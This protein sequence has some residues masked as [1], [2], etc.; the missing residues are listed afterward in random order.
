M[1]FMQYYMVVFWGCSLFDVNF[2]SSFIA[3]QASSNSGLRVI[4]DRY[5][6]PTR[7]SA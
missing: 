5:G 3:A 2:L 4:C 7:G 1:D 6:S